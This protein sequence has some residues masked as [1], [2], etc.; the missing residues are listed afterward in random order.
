MCSVFWPPCGLDAARCPAHVVHLHC[1]QH[2]VAHPL[3]RAN[4]VAGGDQRLDVD[5]THETS[6]GGL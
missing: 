1:L 4:R 3:D 5:Q 2:L 6:L